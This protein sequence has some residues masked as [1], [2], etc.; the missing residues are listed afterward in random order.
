MVFY[1]YLNF[2]YYSLIHWSEYSQNHNIPITDSF[3]MFRERTY[4]HW[5][6]IQYMYSIFNQCYYLLLSRNKKEFFV[7]R[8]FQG[9]SSFWPWAGC[10]HFWT[11]DYL[12][13]KYYNLLG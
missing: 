9:Q 4:Y 5:L 8:I 11:F 1:M 13:D 2:K 10:I 7:N 6:N 3:E 12:Y